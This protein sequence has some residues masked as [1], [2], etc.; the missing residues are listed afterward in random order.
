[1]C[2][3]AVSEGPPMR[4]LLTSLDSL[5]RLLVHGHLHHFGLCRT[6]E[7]TSLTTFVL[8]TMSLP[9][10]LGQEVSTIYI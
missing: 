7:M 10:V 8:L 9:K 3:T 5:H 1:M 4:I 6:S 2:P